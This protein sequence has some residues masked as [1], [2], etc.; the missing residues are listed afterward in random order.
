LIALFV[1]SKRA[2]A[3]SPRWQ[4][5]SAR[6]P[7]LGMVWLPLQ[8]SGNEERERSSPVERKPDAVFA[9]TLR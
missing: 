5:P 6:S 4:M 9:I 1:L 3:S 2:I 8:L 7:L